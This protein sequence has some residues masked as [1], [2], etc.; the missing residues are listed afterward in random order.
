MKRI[1]QQNRRMAE[2]LKI[3]VQARRA[4]C[5]PRSRDACIT[6][7]HSAQAL[8]NMHSVRT[9]N[10]TQE[11]DMLQGEVRL[12]EQERARLMREVKLKTELEVSEGRRARLQ[13][14]GGGCAWPCCRV[15]GTCGTVHPCHALP[16]AAAPVQEGYAKRGAK[17]SAA[18]KDSAAKMATLEGSLAQVGA[19]A[20]A[21][22]CGC[23]RAC[24]QAA[25]N[26]SCTWCRP[27][28][29]G[30]HG[31]GAAGAHPRHKRPGERRWCTLQRC[32]P[33]GRATACA[34]P[35]R[36]GTTHPL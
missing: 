8:C 18:I 31:E 10:A 21:R 19:R 35:L 22:V 9:A 32:A 2:E 11:T 16:A 15:P 3:H 12:L 14:E 30:R 29:H 28:G 17:Q 20:R 36:A 33:C 27:A 25:C 13:A 23:L 34:T 7:G 5:Q 24:T 1:L 6:A 26:A 4:C